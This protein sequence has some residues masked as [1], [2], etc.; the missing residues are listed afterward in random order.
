MPKLPFFFARRYLFS[1]KSVS[2]INIITGISAFTVAVPV[3]AMVILLSVF[4]GFDGLIKSMYKNFDPDIKVTVK[5]GKVFDRSAVENNLHGI[6]EVTGL[7]FVLEGNALFEYR[8]NQYIGTVLGVDSLYSEVVPIENMVVRGEFNPKFGDIDQ[9]LVG[10]GIAYSL[11]MGGSL[12]EPLNIYVPRKGRVFSFMPSDFYRVRSIYLSGIYAL[13][14][15]T[16]GQYVIVPLDFARELM[17]VEEEKVS[18]VYIKIEDSTDANKVRKKIADKLTD[19]FNVQTR[20]QQKESFYR[21]MQYEKWWIYFIILMVLI[22]A[23]FSIIGSLTMIIIDKK[24]DTDTLITLGAGKTLIRKIFITEGMLISCT[25]MI[26]GLILGITVCLLQM[27]FGFIEMAGET[28]MVDAYPVKMKITDIIGVVFSVIFI[29]YIIS[30][31][32]VNS[33]VKK[34]YIS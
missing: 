16:D 29:N 31:I 32:T 24:K 13:D 19:E 22:I 12:I 6:P 33:L 1:A 21:I 34:K 5:E 27:K 30:V 25:G 18:A 14:N 26:I 11:Q 20:F 23:S 28:F 8:N 3:M 15:E 7:S 17:E 9:V 10:Q 4:N 2:A